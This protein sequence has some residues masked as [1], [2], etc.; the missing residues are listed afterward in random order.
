MINSENFSLE[1]IQQLETDT[2]QFLDKSKGDFEELIDLIMT[3]WMDYAN[4][5]ELEDV[6]KCD[7]RQ[8][9][10]RA[11]KTSRQLSLALS[12]ES[13]SIKS[14]ND[15][16]KTEI[17]VDLLT[18]LKNRRAYDQDG[19]AKL[20]AARINKHNVAVVVADIDHFKSVNDRFGHAAGDAVLSNTARLMESSLR[21]DDCIYRIG[22]EEFVILLGDCDLD[23]MKAVCERI[24]MVIE[25]SSVRFEENSISFTVSQGAILVSPSCEL[26]LDELFQM[27]D[28]LLYEAKTNGRNQVRS[29]VAQRL[30][31]S[32]S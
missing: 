26:P 17:A 16:L 15:T 2:C 7:L 31:P 12:A 13:E 18:G 25:S 8:L 9:E 6:T 20:S 28:K 22:G 14:E 1:D 19:P 29:E 32:N 30:V 4:M 24:R 21:A 23:S 5:L 3:E 27:A 11:R 10:K